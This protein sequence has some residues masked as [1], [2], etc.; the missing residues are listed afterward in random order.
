LLLDAQAPSV[1]AMAATTR[2]TPPLRHKR[3][4]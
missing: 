3:L 1:S 4:L 2:A